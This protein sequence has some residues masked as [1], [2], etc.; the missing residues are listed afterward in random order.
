MYLAAGE[1]SLRGV[2]YMPQAGASRTRAV[3]GILAAATTTTT[4]TYNLI[5]VAT[6]SLSTSCDGELTIMTVE[7]GSTP[8]TVGRRTFSLSMESGDGIA[9]V[10]WAGL[11][12]IALMS[13]AGEVICL[14]SG[15]QDDSNNS[16]NDDNESNSDNSDIGEIEE[17]LLRAETHA[18]DI[19]ALTVLGCP[20]VV[21][22]GHQRIHSFAFPTQSTSGKVNPETHEFNIGP[23]NTIAGVSQKSVGAALL[24]GCTLGSV[25]VFEWE[26]HSVSPAPLRCI[27]MGP[28]TRYIGI[29]SSSCYQ[30]KTGYETTFC[31]FG[32]TEKKKENKILHL[33][34][35]SLQRSDGVPFEIMETDNSEFASQLPSWN[36]VCRSSVSR[37]HIIGG[38][39]LLIAQP[40]IGMDYVVPHVL[41]IR[42]SQEKSKTSKVAHLGKQNVKSVE[43][44]SS[45]EFKV[46]EV[47]SPE[48]E[49]VLAKLGSSV[50]VIPLLRRTNH[51]D[52]QDYDTFC[53][54]DG[55]CAAFFGC[56]EEK[57]QLESCGV[58]KPNAPTEWMAG[59]AWTPQS[60][61]V[62]M[63]SGTPL[64]ADDE[65]RQQPNT[66][67]NTNKNNTNTSRN[68]ATVCVVGN[69][70]VTRAVPQVRRVGSWR[71]RVERRLA[72]VERAV[73][74]LLRNR[75]RRRPLVRYPA[76]YP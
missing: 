12:V 48:C 69:L 61:D 38:S 43:A 11:T 5:A 65:Q 55:K 72:A 54:F 67:N 19:C 30:V 15:M 35:L 64:N 47:L 21:V 62:L 9:K 57:L 2:A 76:L 46:I 32:E 13:S 51:C 25:T 34:T 8:M 37:P 53:L 28:S 20:V 26:S 3:T 73:G 6:L 45:V 4:R 40:Q 41:C 56:N 42:V 17:L 68:N 36:D 60:D 75:G 23:F 14:S 59:V 74:V 49:H 63:L 70:R 27:I 29:A 10:V 1:K 39:S 71:R 24:V 50:S 16:D 52:S 7:E 22:A 44:L 58:I 66:E 33:P 18:V 31:V